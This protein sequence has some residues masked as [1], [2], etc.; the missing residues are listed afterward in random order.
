MTRVTPRSRPK[1][2]GSGPAWMVLIGTR[3]RR[4]SAEATSPPPH[5]RAST[6]RL[7]RGDQ[8]GVGGRQRPG[9][10]RSSASPSS[11]ASGASR[12]RVEA[13]QRLEPGVGGAGWSTAQMLV[14]TSA[15]RAPPSLAWVK[16][17]AKPVRACTSRT[18][19][20]RSSRGPGAPRWPPGAPSGS[21][22]PRACPSGSTE[23]SSPLGVETIVGDGLAGARSA[24][25]RP[26]PGRGAS[27][28]GRSPRRPRARRLSVRHTA[29]RAASHAA[30]AEQALSGVSIAQRARREHVAA[31]DRAPEPARHREPVAGP[32]EPATGGLELRGPALRGERGR[33]AARAACRVEQ[34]AARGRGLDLEPARARAGT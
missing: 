27:T 29:G 5:S 31:A 24:V 7:G 9:R 26:G 15:A 19:S 21:A 32:V 23:R 11:A 20:G 25:S 2:R 1:Q 33:V 34:S 22:A 4:P 13:H 17:S 3:K 18:S 16:R 14:A 12:G 6:I 28:S 30:Q 8:R 10:G